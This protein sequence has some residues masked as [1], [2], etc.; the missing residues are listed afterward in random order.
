MANKY[1]YTGFKFP[2]IT[3]NTSPIL[4]QAHDTDLIKGDLYQLLLTEFGER[5][6]MPSYG[7]GL[8]KIFFEQKSSDVLT[9]IRSL[10]VDSIDKWEQ[11]IVVNS[12]TIDYLDS[13]RFPERIRAVNSSIDSVAG[14]SV[15]ISI[16]FSIKENLSVSDNLEMLVTQTNSG[17]IRSKILENTK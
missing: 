2:L 10:I 6:M 12:I 13:E 9:D 4:A 16:D 7:T 17:D 15:L 3:T 1:I 8:R 11:R 5:V 14:N